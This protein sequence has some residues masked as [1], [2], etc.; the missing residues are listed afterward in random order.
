MKEGQTIALSAKKNHVVITEQKFDDLGFGS[1][2]PKRGI[3]PI[4][5]GSDPDEMLELAQEHTW[6]LGDEADESGFYTA[7]RVK[8]TVATGKEL[9]GAK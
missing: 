9:A 6:E 8:E 4:A 2:K 3:V 7:R 5:E 1:G